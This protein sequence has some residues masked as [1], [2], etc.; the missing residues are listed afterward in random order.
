MAAKS[1]ED[2]RAVY[3]SWLLWVAASCYSWVE[4]E[5]EKWDLFTFARWKRKKLRDLGASMH[6]HARTGN[7]LGA[8]CQIV[9]KAFGCASFFHLASKWYWEMHT[10]KKILCTLPIMTPHPNVG[11]D[12][13]NCLRHRASKKVSLSVWT[14][15]AS[16]T[17]W[18]GGARFFIWRYHRFSLPPPHFFSGEK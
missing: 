7:L 13:R 11:T 15:H 1:A 16:V 12:M 4:R 9:K 18:Q 10:A 8:V 17:L 2:W 6:I 3:Y 5:R 14:K